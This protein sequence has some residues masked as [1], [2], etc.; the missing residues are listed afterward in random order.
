MFST[1]Y[2]ESVFYPIMEEIQIR[3]ERNL[4]ES[5]HRGLNVREHYWYNCSF[6][7]GAENQAL[8]NSDKEILINFVYRWS[9][10][11]GS[12]AKHPGFDMFKYYASVDNTRYLKLS[13]SR[14]FH[15]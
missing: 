3:R 9:K 11:K 13:F 5:I 15:L 2:I 1:T 12:K 14:V 10:Y 6:L 7:G 4:A 8:E